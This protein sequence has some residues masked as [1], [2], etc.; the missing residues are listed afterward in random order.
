MSHRRPCPPRF[1]WRRG[2]RRSSRVTPSATLFTDNLKQLTTHFFSPNPA[3]NGTIRAT[4]EHS[5]DTSIVWGGRAIP[6][7]DPDFV[8]QDA[9]PWLLLPMAGVQ[10]GPTGGHTLTATT[11]I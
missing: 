7:S 6:S 10:E 11:F 1:R 4:W 5:K 2:T 8:A 3:E 9:I